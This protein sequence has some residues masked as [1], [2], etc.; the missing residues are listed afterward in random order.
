M[1]GAGTVTVEFFG[2]PRHQAGRAELDVPAGTLREVLAAVRVSCPG[3]AGLV[4]DGGELS[5]HYLLSIDGVRFVR[6][7][8]E[9]V[10][11]GVRVLLLSA[12]A[13]G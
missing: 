11:P 5:P 1:P 8:Q 2:I 4:R 6:D 9:S 3:L 10:Q 13:G 7:V 12:D